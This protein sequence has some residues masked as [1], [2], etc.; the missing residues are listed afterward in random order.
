MKQ[1]VY[2]HYLDVDELDD[3]AQ[4]LGF[5]GWDDLEKWYWS[6][7]RNNTQ[8]EMN[9][10]IGGPTLELELHWMEHPD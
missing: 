7:R 1:H 2:V 5:E 10:G 8:L 3:I 9:F 4:E 6:R